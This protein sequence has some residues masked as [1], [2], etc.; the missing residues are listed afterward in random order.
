MAKSEKASFEDMVSQ[1]IDEVEVLKPGHV[2]A[3]GSELAIVEDEEPEGN[4]ALASF[5]TT[6]S[7][8]DADDIAMPRL[9]LAQGLTKE[10]QEGFAKPGQWIVTGYN[11]VDQVT[12]IPLGVAKFRRRNDPAEGSTLCRSEDSIVGIGDP[13]GDCAA[14]PFAQWG[15]KNAAGRQ[16]PPE[17]TFGYRYLVNIIEPPLGQ[18]VLELKKTGLNAG[19]TLNAMAIQRVG[20]GRFKAVLVPK[21]GTSAKGSF[22]TPSVVPVQE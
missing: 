12:I 2:G 15:A 19:K 5:N 20:W 17:C 6:A 7:G 18:A 21:K 13:G 10:V 3:T 14:C 22:Y 11:P 9:R 4:Y 1:D 16:A 8:L